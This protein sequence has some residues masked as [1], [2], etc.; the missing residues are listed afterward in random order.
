[1]KNYRVLIV[2]L[3]LGL[4]SACSGYDKLLKGSDVGK[5]YEGALDYYNKGDFVRAGTLFDMIGQYYRG[6]QRADTVGFYYAYCLYRQQDY[7]MAGHSFKEFADAYPR[8]KFAEQADFLNCYCY[9][10]NAPKPELDQESTHDALDALQLFMLKYPGSSRLSECSKLIQELRER[11]MTKEY[12]SSRMYYDLGYYKASIIAMRN[13]LTDFP[14][15][16]YREDLMYLVVLANFN[17]A[18]N[19]VPEKQKER[20]QGTLDEYYSF[21]AEFPKSKYSEQMQKVYKDLSAQL[22]L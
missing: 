14:D 3:A 17:F 2:L 21:V 19:S 4:L 1:M 22:N 10:L 18:Q 15:N 11:L 13:A 6:T 9:Y 20:F 5:K 16:K 8:S 7:I 12:L